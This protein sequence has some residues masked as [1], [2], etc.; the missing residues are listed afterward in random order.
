MP[1][2]LTLLGG[3][4]VNVL[5]NELSVDAGGRAFGFFEFALVGGCRC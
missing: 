2:M 4:P 3:S 5:I 1:S